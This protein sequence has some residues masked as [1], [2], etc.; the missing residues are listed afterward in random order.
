MSENGATINEWVKHCHSIAKDHGWHD[1]ERS[2]LEIIALMHSELSEAVEEVR[3]NTP[4]VYQEQ[5]QYAEIR[6]SN[7]RSF[8]VS[9]EKEKLVREHKWYISIHGYVLRTKDDLSLHRFLLNAEKTEIIDHI[10]RTPLDNRDCNLR[11]V[12][13]QQNQINQNP[14]KNKKYKGVYKHSKNNSFVAQITC[15]Y[16]YNYIGSFPTEKEAARAYDEK[17]LELFGEFAYLNFPSTEKE[18]KNKIVTP[19]DIEWNSSLKPEGE[20]IELVDVIIRIF[21]YFGKKN[22]DLENLLQIKCTYNSER[23]HRHGGKLY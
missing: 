6:I 21:D 15:N 9:V 4:P 11:K 5:K 18:S 14:S 12:T 17:A 7:F 16:K 8:I 23:S 2:P 20:A 1:T 22:W 10:N 19:E 3:R 13:K